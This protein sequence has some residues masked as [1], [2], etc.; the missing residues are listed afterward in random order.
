[1]SSF[2]F[3]LTKYG[4]ALVAVMGAF[5]ARLILEPILGAVAPLQMFSLAVVLSAWYGGFGPGILATLASDVLGDYFFIE[6]LHSFQINSHNLSQQAELAIFLVIGASISVLSHERISSKA[7]L[8]QL[9]VRESEAR[10][11]AESANRLKDEFLATVSHELRTPLNAILGWSTLLRQGRLDPVKSDQAVETIER[12]AKIQ[13]RLI[14]D[15]LDVS[16]IIS[17]KLQ[18]VSERIRLTPIIEAAVEMIRPAADAKDVQL[19]LALNPADDHV[20]GDSTRLQQVVWNLLSNAVKFTPPGGRIEVTLDRVDS[21]AQITVRDTG[22]GISP[23]FLPYVFERFRQAD[24]KAGGIGLGMAIARSL[25]ELHG[26]SIE[27]ESE[28]LGQ[29]TTF[30]V[31]IPSVNDES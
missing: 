17:G 12:N 19:S 2:F 20:L 13:L 23:E 29:G 11:E 31:L 16:R 15:L 21:M 27:V 8:Q 30:T 24:S 5:A 28:G 9:L 4:W 3:T 7:R 1:M 18:I 25:M 10:G 6:P 14:D 22:K 26:G